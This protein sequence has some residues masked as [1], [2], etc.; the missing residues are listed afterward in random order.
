M[1]RTLSINRNSGIE[2]RA[3]VITVDH[4]ILHQSDAPSIT[5][6]RQTFISK[7]VPLAIQA[8][9]SAIKEARLDKVDITHIVC[10]TS[11]DGGSPGL[12]RLLHLKLVLVASV[13][14]T[15]L[16]G[17]SALA[18]L[19][20]A[21]NIALGCTAMGKSAQILCV[22]LDVNTTM[23]RTE[24][25]SVNQLQEPRIGA[26][27]FSDCASAL[28]LSNGVGDQAR[29]VYELLR[30]N[31]E[32]IPDTENDFGFE[33]N[34]TG[35]KPHLSDKLPSVLSEA[36]APGFNN[37]IGLPQ[38]HGDRPHPANFDWA[39][40]PVGGPVLSGAENALEITAE[41]L[42][43]SYETYNKHGY[44]GSAALFSILDR[45]RS[46]EMDTMTSRGQGR[47]Y[48]IG[49]SFSPGVVLDMCMLRRSRNGDRKDSKCSEISM[50]NG[51]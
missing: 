13:E 46:A 40:D 5:Q 32:T 29:S 24:L 17:M 16:H 9:V 1:Q 7:G 34:A 12:D 44:A 43:A 4:P 35:W 36:L 14:T 51:Q 18:A 8:A 50:Q 20:T 11:T 15:L 37:L 48:I 41:H 30:W 10:T 2:S 25:D 23:L 22:T 42:R 26:C 27:L 45:L 6:V 39:I 28:V 31:S 49:C 33:A 3:S 21:A 38:L 19:R 47:D